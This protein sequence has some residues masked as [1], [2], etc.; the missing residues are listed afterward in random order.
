MDNN[1]S[2]LNIFRLSVLI[3][4]STILISTII[5][6]GI[7]I[8][9]IEPSV[10]P[11]FFDG[12]W[13]AIVTVF[14]VGYGDL[15]P[16]T[17]AG[18][19]TAILLILIGT[20][21]GSYYM[22]SFATELVSRQYM[23]QKGQGVCG[24]Q[25][26]LILIGW[27]ERTK[28]IVEQTKN[29]IVLVDE[30]LSV[31]PKDYSHL[32]FIKGCPHHDETL[33]RAG[34]SKA[35]TIIVTADKEKKEK[36]AD[37]Q[38]ILHVLTAK[39]LNAHLYCIAE[40]LTTAQVENAKRAGADKV[41]EANKLI[42]STFMK[43]AH[44]IKENTLSPHLIC[45]LSSLPGQEGRTFGDLAITLL[46]DDKLLIGIQRNTEQLINPGFTFLLQEKDA[47]ITVKK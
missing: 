27:N 31:L 9:Y 19:T 21:F 24:F 3:R 46:K 2:V 8:H 5:G 40:I 23:K 7:I 39:S 36:E 35:T 11:T 34:I 43:K 28:L 29:P 45:I 10:F 18:K 30:T 22:I 44:L 16:K 13:W 47:L 38:T 20:G 12:I 6:F 14:T 1:T 17:L 42:S 33:M 37:A 26:H 15:V 32:F 41:I 4:I 25:N